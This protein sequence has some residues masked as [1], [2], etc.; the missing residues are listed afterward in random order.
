MGTF[1]TCDESHRPKPQEETGNGAMAG[2]NDFF[3]STPAALCSLWAQLHTPGSHPANLLSPET[4]WKD[5]SGPFLWPCHWGPWV[6][7]NVEGK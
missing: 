2:R 4:G 1:L 7:A 6:K 3:T 5:L